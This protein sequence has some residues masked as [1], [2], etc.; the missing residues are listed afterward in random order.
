VPN[1]KSGAA[2]GF[3]VKLTLFEVAPLS[4]TVT[5]NIPAVPTNAAVTVPVI[6][7]GWPA[8]LVVN[9]VPL[10]FTTEFAEKFEPFTVSVNCAAPAVVDVGEIEVIMGPVT[11][12][13]NGVDVFPVPVSVTVIGNVPPAVRSPGGTVAVNAVGCPAV[14]VVSA[15]PLKLTTQF[16]EKFEPLTV[17]VNCGEP[18]FTDNGLNAEIAGVGLPIAG[19]ANSQALRPCVPASNSRLESCSASE[20]T[21]TLGKPGAR[22]LQCAPPFEVANTPIS[23]PA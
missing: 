12:N 7:V 4:V 1:E 8:V 15:A 5:G 2:A 11:V 14:L 13:V 17:K 22:V 19:S 18:A 23:V 9:A 10:K 20:S 3:T 6:E 21:S 16:A